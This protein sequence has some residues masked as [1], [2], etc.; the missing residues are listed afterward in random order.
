MSKFSTALRTRM[1]GTEG[2]K[3]LLAGGVLLLFGGAIPATAEAAATG[4]LLATL[5]VSGTPGAGLSFDDPLA[6]VLSKLPSEVWMTSSI[7]VSGNVTHY[8]YVGAGD[9]GTEDPDC[10]R[11]QG[12]VGLAGTDMV[13]T[14]VA[15]TAGLPWTLNY[16]SIGLPTD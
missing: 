8:R 12:T 16:F 11:I 5:T 13:V 7:D 1:L 9:D 10:I 14:N 2:A 15:M 4:T 3:T 6:G